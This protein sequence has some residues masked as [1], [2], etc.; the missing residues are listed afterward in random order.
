MAEA[1][2]QSSSHFDTQHPG[3]SD[4]A[5]RMA[6]SPT[7]DVPFTPQQALAK[8]CHQ[9]EGSSHNYETP[10]SQLGDMPVA[11]LAICTF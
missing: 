9:D 4:P 1:V 8:V 6:V 11:P 5:P 3:Y 2:H 10:S 7:A